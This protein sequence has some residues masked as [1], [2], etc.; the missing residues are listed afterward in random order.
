MGKL[1]I[2]LLLIPT[3]SFGQGYASFGNSNPSDTARTRN[4]ML[5]ERFMR[6]PAYAPA[7]GDTTIL[8]VRA[9]NGIVFAYSLDGLLARI[10]GYIG[11]P[12]LQDI[13]N[14]SSVLNQ[15]NT[16]T[17]LTKNLTLR[18]QS[19]DWKTDSLRVFGILEMQ[20]GKITYLVEPTN[21]DPLD[22]ATVKYVTESSFD[23]V[24]STTVTALTS[25]RFYRTVSTINYG[26]IT[27]NSNYFTQAGTMIT[28][29]G[30]TFYN[31]QKLTFNLK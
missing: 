19:G 3:L 14:N 28:F 13:L 18:G 20:D 23:S 4:H 9:S 27:Y 11:T 6:F 7:T 25:P 21:Y 22:V 24:M 5:V 15:N 16:I 26:G 29:I 12:G 17:F 10:G 1:L 31:G 30:L 2:I 8:S